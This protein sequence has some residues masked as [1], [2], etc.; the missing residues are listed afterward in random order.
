MKIRAYD[1]G[2]E[3][4]CGMGR[5][6]LRHDAVVHSCLPFQ[7]HR[8]ELLLSYLLSPKKL[9]CLDIFIQEV[10]ILMLQRPPKRDERMG[11]SRWLAS[12]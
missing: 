5:P 12:E 10:Q 7:M 4:L 9:T 8:L 1:T 3:A 6:L 11:K 2:K